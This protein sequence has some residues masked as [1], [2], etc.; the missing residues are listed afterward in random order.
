MRRPP[1]RRDPERVGTLVPRV[2]EDLGF[3]DSV[4]VMRI[5]E[6]WEE[7]VGPAI[8][9]HGQPTALRGDVLEVT[10]DSSPWCQQLQLRRPDI[11]SALRRA[12]GD[13]APSDVWFRVGSR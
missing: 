2:L 3:G 7:A 12:L 1:P 6:R 11:L 13:E 4:R 5:A 8:A 9:L 10:V